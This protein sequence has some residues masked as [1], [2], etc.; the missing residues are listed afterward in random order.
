MKKVVFLTILLLSHSVCQTKM[1]NFYVSEVVTY[2]VDNLT[3]SCEPNI[4][5]SQIYYIKL[6]R[7]YTANN[8]TDIVTKRT[9]HLGLIPVWYDNDIRQRSHY[10]FSDKSEKSLIYKISREHVLLTDGGLYA[11]TISG[12]VDDQVVTE[13]EIQEI[14]ILCKC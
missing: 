12:L 11:C 9:T 10:D 8:W 2:M 13:D 7:L 6:T 14:Q 4:L 1:I 5:M 3:I